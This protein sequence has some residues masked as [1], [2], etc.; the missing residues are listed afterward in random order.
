MPNTNV[1]AGTFGK[2]LKGA[3]IAAYIRK[4]NID[5][6]NNVVRYSS[7][8]DPGHMRAVPGTSGW[9]G[10]LDYELNATG[11]TPDLPQLQRGMVI[12][13]VE[14]HVD[15]S[16]SNA[17]TGD[18]VIENHNIITDIETDAVVGGTIT[19]VG[20][21]AL[22]RTGALLTDEQLSSS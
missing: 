2:I 3:V 21:G 18:L 8:R 16:G 10:S 15:D 11:S 17:L 7:S 14:F 12:D 4:W 9:T 13:A 6:T 19:F 5:E 22:G 1:F 20:D